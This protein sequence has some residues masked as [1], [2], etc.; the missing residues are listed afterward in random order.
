MYGLGIVKG[1]SVTLKHFVETFLDD[2]HWFG[3]RN[4]LATFQTKQGLGGKGMY[5]VQYPEEKIAVPER[6]R[7]IPFLVT[8]NNDDPEYPG[9]DW[10]TSCGICAKVCPPQCIWI[11]RGTDA[12][13]GRPKPEPEQFYIDI[14]ICMNC[15]YCA[16]YCPFDAIR[17]DH[18][19][20]LASYDRT[21][22][23]IYDHSKLTKE[24]R[25]WQAI[26]PTTAAEEMAARGGYDQTDTQK[27]RK[28]AGLPASRPGPTSDKPEAAP[29][30]AAAV[31]PNAVVEAHPTEIPADRVA[32]EQAAAVSASISS[33]GSA[34][35][36]EGKPIVRRRGNAGKA[37]TPGATPSAAAPTTAAPAA[38]PTATPAAAALAPQ[39]PTPAAPPSN[40]AASATPAATPQPSK[41]PAADLN[42]PATVVRRRN[43]PPPKKD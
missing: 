19:Y 4:S 27:M 16:E 15:G 13:T 38:A 33:T 7:Y 17:M 42:K 35:T 22:N 12:T 2:I 28:K 10:C 6:F 39:Q 31:I 5:T 23:H 40:V 30:A 25:Y 9:K 41:P 3:Q 18:D 20:E 37:A 32:P 36:A 29:V 11:V 43:S 24:I 8:Y 14:D 34:T 1:L 26:A 21:G